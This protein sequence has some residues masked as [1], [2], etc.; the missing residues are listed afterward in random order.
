MWTVGLMGP[1][2]DI[3]VSDDQAIA[4]RVREAAA[5]AA[6]HPEHRCFLDTFESIDRGYFVRRGLIDRRGDPTPAGLALARSSTED[7]P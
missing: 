6:G 3:E 2:P 1:R 5:F 4:R 7:Q